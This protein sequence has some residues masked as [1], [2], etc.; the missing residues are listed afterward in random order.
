[1]QN[2]T[3]TKQATHKSS[4]THLPDSITTVSWGLERTGAVV[5]PAP[6]AAAV[7]LRGASVGMLAGWRA[8]PVVKD[9][10]MS[11]TPPAP[12]AAAAFSSLKAQGT[13]LCRVVVSG[14]TLNTWRSGDDGRMVAE[15]L[16]VRF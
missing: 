12:A 5:L 9:T 6:Q 3:T 13:L 7:V 10:R 4:G 15:R 1:M 11:Y 14:G 2:H 16:Q 8:V